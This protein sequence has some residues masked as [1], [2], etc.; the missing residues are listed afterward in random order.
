MSTKSCILLKPNQLC[1]GFVLHTIFL[2]LDLKYQIKPSSHIAHRLPIPGQ[3]LR[4]SRIRH[5][6][7]TSHLNYK[8]PW[9][10][11]RKIITPWRNRSR[12]PRHLPSSLI[13]LEVR[14]F[15][16]R[17][18]RWL[19]QRR[20]RGLGETILGLAEFGQLAG[21]SYVYVGQRV[22]SYFTKG[23]GLALLPF[24]CLSPFLGF[25]IR[26]RAAF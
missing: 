1:R 6:M 7:K 18:V 26:L 25:D 11:H 5:S 21:D 20:Q 14:T 3:T 4:R 8:F 13:Q 17:M 12:R 19:N 23:F 10:F 22:P 15:L 9:L 16:T 2:P 24:G